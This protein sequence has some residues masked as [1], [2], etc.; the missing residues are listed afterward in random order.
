[1]LLKIRLHIC[2]TLKVTIPGSTG[3]VWFLAWM[4]IVHDS[5]VSHPRISAKE[6]DYIVYTLKSELDISKKV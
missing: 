2:Q 1:M 3:I 4:Y 6:R 5:P